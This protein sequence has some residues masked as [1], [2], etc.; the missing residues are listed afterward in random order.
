MGDPTALPSNRYS[1]GP[2]PPAAAPVKTTLAPTFCGE[3]R[4]EDSVGAPRFRTNPTDAL[5]AS[6]AEPTVRARTRNS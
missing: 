6:A 3:A 2:A 4:F 5:A 1:Y